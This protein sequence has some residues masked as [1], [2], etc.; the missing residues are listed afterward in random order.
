MEVKLHLLGRSL[1]L[2]AGG[3]AFMHRYLA[4]LAERLRHWFVV[5]KD[6]QRL[7]GHAR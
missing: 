2:K 7:S 5:Q 3:K 1:L 4:Y 6:F